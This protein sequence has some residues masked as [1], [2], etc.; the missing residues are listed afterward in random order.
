MKQARKRILKDKT[1]SW[2][3]GFADEVFKEI[4]DELQGV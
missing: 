2:G 3:T 1:K 4:A